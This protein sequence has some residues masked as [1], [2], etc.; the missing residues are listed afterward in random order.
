VAR[1]SRSSRNSVG[2]NSQS[3]FSKIPQANIQRSVFDRSAQHKTTFDS[4]LLIPFFVDEILPGDTMKASSHFL[5]RL[6]T[7]IF[8]YMDNVFLD[9]HYFFV[10]NRLVWDNWEELN[11]AQEDPGDSTDFLVPQLSAATHSAGFA[12]NSIY[13]YL[14]LPTKIAGIDQPDMPNALILRAYNLIWNE[15]YRDENLQNSL[16]VPKD[17][18]PDDEAYALQRRGRRKDYFTS[19]LPWPQKGPSVLL[20]LG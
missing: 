13:D 9:V 1:K 19:S 4:G 5:A 8:P 18:G 7:P 14:G 3:H 17:D 11:G 6:A 20:P 16:P 12:E 2:S 10:P 15:W